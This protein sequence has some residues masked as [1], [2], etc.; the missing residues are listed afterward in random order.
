M[1]FEVVHQHNMLFYGS[2]EGHKKSINIEN[3]IGGGW[4]NMRELRCQ[5]TSSWER[6]QT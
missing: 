1:V 3:F 2:T 5:I 6:I 4:I